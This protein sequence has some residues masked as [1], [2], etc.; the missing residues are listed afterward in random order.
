MDTVEIE[1]PRQAGKSAA[2]RALII[3][4]TGY[5]DVGKDTVA[6]ILAPR[7][8]FRRIAFADALRAEVCEAW[9]IDERMLTHRPTKELPLPALAAGM[10]GDAAFARWCADSGESLTEPR[11]PRWVMQ[12]WATFQR[13]FSPAYYARLVARWIDRQ[14]GSGWN[15]IVVSD[16]RDEVEEEM[17][18]AM[19]AKVIRVHR[20]D[21]RRLD[22]ATAAH[23]SEEHGRIQADADIV[24]D[25]SLAAL[26]E[27]TLEC[28]TTLEGSAE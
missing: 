15:R 6:G 27:I 9:R 28:V 21:A 18:R 11:S 24:N 19:G 14:V 20:L 10:C 4:L 8:G 16:L 2:R 7:H 25:G 17:L 22:G 26:A 13:R 23:I 3:A 1:R 12:T 5:P